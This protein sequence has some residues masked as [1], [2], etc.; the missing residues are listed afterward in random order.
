MKPISYGKQTIG[1]SDIISV[2]RTLVSPYLTQGPKIQELE[3]KL[4]EYV[5]A[6]YCIVCSNGTSALNLIAKLLPEKSNIRVPDITFMATANAFKL[7]NHNIN[8]YDID[9]K[10]PLLSTYSYDEFNVPVHMMGYPSQTFTLYQD[11]TIEDA[12]HALSAS[13]L[14]LDSHLHMVGDCVNSIATVFSFHPVKPITCGEGGAITTNSESLY[15]EL[16]KLRNHGISIING[17]YQLDTPSLNF[18]LTDIQASLLISQLKKLNSFTQKRTEIAKYYDQHLSQWAVIPEPWQYPSYH[19]Y[20]IRIP[21]RDFV[22]SF[23]QSKGINTQIH[24]QPIHQ[25]NCYKDNYYDEEFPNA[26][27]YYNETLSLPIYPAL[28]RSE[29]NYIIKQL[30]IALDKVYK[31]DI[32]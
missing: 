16:K 4:A 17:K 24:Y 11:N 23:L 30:K 15:L 18:R 6:K 22:K 27:H 8:L 28:K 14:G 26:I 12:C 29:Q 19:L 21:K 3:E 9:N 10:Q 7:E 32:M 2:I 13:Y 25:F 31:N 5:G 20:V 1:V